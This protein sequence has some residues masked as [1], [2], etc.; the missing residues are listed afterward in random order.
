MPK[1]VRRPSLSRYA[2]Y[3]F[4]SVAAIQASLICWFSVRFSGFFHSEYRAPFR[5]LARS[6]PGL[7]GASAG[8][9]PRPRFGSDR[10]S[11]RASFQAPRRTSSRASVAHFTTWNGSATRTAPGQV[12]AT[13]V[14]MKSAP[15]AETW[16]IWAHRCGPHQTS[17]VVVDHDHQK[18]ESALVADLIDPD[19]A[20]PGQA[21][22]L[23]VDVGPDPG[24]ARPDSAPRDPHQRG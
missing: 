18:L 17:C 11:A 3:S 20:Q 21:V 6:L 4:G 19:P 22:M 12:A 5:P 14:S 8:G 10:A 23:G 9:R 16:V 15:S 13:M 1:I 2:R 24:D 7:G